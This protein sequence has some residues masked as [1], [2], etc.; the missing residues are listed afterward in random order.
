ME[1]KKK[2]MIDDFFFF[3]LWSPQQTFKFILEYTVLNLVARI[4]LKPTKLLFFT[5]RHCQ[6]TK[7]SQDPF[8]NHLLNKP[9]ATIKEQAPLLPSLEASEP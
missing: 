7:P 4:Y 8:P 6:M 9:E 2:P 5:K 3:I 1:R